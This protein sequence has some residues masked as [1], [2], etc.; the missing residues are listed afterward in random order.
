MKGPQT[1]KNTEQNQIKIETKA[2]LW[3]KQ[4]G[5]AVRVRTNCHS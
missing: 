2:E 1:N 5:E 4:P 3:P